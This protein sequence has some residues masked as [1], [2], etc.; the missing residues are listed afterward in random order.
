MAVESHSL[1]NIMLYPLGEDGVQ[2]SCQTCNWVELFAAPIHLHDIK[3]AHADYLRK[4]RRLN[5][6]SDGEHWGHAPEKR[7]SDGDGQ[8]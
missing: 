5:R 2:A 3:K 4:L 1:N 6:E 8:S 7:F